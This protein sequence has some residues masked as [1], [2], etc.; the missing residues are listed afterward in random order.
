MFLS[1]NTTHML[2]HRPRHHPSAFT[3]RIQHHPHPHPPPSASAS[4]TIRI[5]IHHHPHPHPPQD[6]CLVSS[7]FFTFIRICSPTHPHVNASSRPRIRTPTHL[8]AHAS[9]RQRIHPHASHGPLTIRKVR[10][11]FLSFLILIH[12][13]HPQLPPSVSARNASPSPPHYL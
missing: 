8:H 11:F 6:F 2:S 5:R 10:T 4:T 12:V 3:I 7:F 9:A 13:H 1:P